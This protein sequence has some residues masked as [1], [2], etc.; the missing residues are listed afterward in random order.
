MGKAKAAVD[1]FAPVADRARLH[2][3]FAELLGSPIHQHARVFMAQLARRMG[4]PNGNFI[5]D[6]QTDGFHSR[7]FELG[8]FAYLEEAGLSLDRRYEQPDFLVSKNGIHAAIEAVTANP[9]TGQGTDISLRQMEQ[10]SEDQ[11]LEKVSREFPRR[12]AKVLGRKLSHNYHDLPQCKGKPLVLVTGP[13][14]EAGANFYT[15]DALFHPLF[16]TPDG[17]D[18]FEPFF[19]RDDAQHVSAVLY[20]NQF[21]VSKF[22]RL[23]TDLAALDWMNAKWGGTCFRNRD[24]ESYEISRFNFNLR[25]P[26]KPKES[27][28]HGVTLFENPYARHPL[29]QGL[30]PASSRVFVDVDGIVTRNV[31]EFHPVVSFMEMYIAEGTPDHL[32]IPNK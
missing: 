21:T 26:D 22:L 30:L 32:W 25:A 5:R 7:L 1:L 13:F 10:L 8:C 19:Q 31:T 3:Q 6:F 28:A 20:C 2:P 18:E 11:I 27:W 14:F 9:P 15:D 16:G 24:D 17:R 4:D 12:M 29:P 23:S